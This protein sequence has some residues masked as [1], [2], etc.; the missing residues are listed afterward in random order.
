M[1]NPHDLVRF[2]WNESVSHAFS[3][4]DLEHCE[5]G[6]IVRV[7]RGECDVVTASGQIRAHTGAHS[8]CTGDWVTV[9]DSAVTDVLPRRSA[10]VRASASIRSESQVLAANV[11]TVV[12]AAALDTDV[13]LGR[14]ERFL[15]LAWE[16]GAMPV[17]VLTKADATLDV[18]HTLAD[19]AAIAPGATVLA[20]SAR[21]GDGL[22]VLVAAVDGTVALVGQSGAGKSTLANALLGEDL[23]A[24]GQVRGGDHKGRHVTAHRELVP[25]PGGGTLIDTPGLRGVGLW[26]AADGIGRAFSEIDVLAEQCRFGD[27]NHAA[28]P[29]CAVR[30][31]VERDELPQRRLDSY[32]K[33]QRENEWMAARTDARLQAERTRQVKVLSRSLKEHYRNR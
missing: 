5:P 31:A 9:R 3:T 28:E 22:D 16:S 6:R 8:V 32:R 33:L 17:V 21:T 20:V 30:E 19:V 29:G 13:D 14:I 7:D 1:S 10:I 12:I 24:T 2:G 15:A 25:L 27:C 11:D 4:L 23:F 26:D 18:S